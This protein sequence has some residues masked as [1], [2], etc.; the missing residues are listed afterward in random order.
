[1]LEPAVSSVWQHNPINIL[2]KP[3][4]AH[5]IIEQVGGNSGVRRIAE[6]QTR[7]RRRSSNIKQLLVI[8]DVIYLL[9]AVG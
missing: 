1:M 4:V 3:K 2:S 6:R 8:Y 7:R 5:L 9:T